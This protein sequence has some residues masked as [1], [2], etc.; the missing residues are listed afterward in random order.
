LKSRDRF[1]ARSHYRPASKLKGHH[2]IHRAQSIPDL[3]DRHIAGDHLGFGP[4]GQPHGHR[5]GGV[6]R[7][8]Q[9]EHQDRPDDP[10]QQQRE[11]FMFE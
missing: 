10:V 2:G 3:D 1:S 5:H 11:A 9:Q 4:F 8:G 6:Q 7:H